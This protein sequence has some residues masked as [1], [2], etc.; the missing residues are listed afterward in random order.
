MLGWDILWVPD[1]GNL[2]NLGN[3]GDLGNQII[4]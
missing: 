2:G 3:L 1:A 4:S